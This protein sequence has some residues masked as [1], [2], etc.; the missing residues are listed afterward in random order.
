MYHLLDFFTMCVLSLNISQ[1]FIY[2]FWILKV[3]SNVSYQIY[4]MY[5]FVWFCFAFWFHFSL[6]C[7]VWVWKYIL[8]HS[9]YHFL[10]FCVDLA[11]EVYILLHYDFHFLLF[12]VV[13]VW[14]YILLIS[15]FHFLIFCLSIYF[16]ILN[17]TF[18]YFLNFSLENTTFCEATKKNIEI[19]T[20]EDFWW[21]LSIL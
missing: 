15:G 19:G 7:L 18:Y 9:D 6:F 1:T 13:W 3:Y 14:K 12:C 11:L 8:L 5:C 4:W 17:S 16:F 21:Y 10:L 2:F 20:F